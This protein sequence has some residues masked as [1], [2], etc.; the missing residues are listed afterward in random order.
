MRAA[1]SL[2]SFV[3]ALLGLPASSGFAA[4]PLTRIKDTKVAVD[5]RATS[6]VVPPTHALSQ[7]VTLSNYMRLPCEQYVLIPMPLGSN[8]SVRSDDGE[9]GG[10]R[11]GPAAERS[12]GD[13]SNKCILRGSKFIETS[14]LNDRFDFSVTTTLTWEDALQ[15]ISG[16]G[17]IEGLQ[18]EECTGCSITADTSIDVDV[19]VPPPFSRIPKRILERTGNAAMR[20]SLRYIQANFVNNLAAD[21]AK[22]ATDSAYRKYRASLSEGVGVEEE[23]MV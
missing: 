20:L 6:S 1:A 7:N 16:D 15:S 13:T 18:L 10:V 4:A 11:L 17:D 8:L 9:A 21:Y 22:W 5:G 2:G 23:V 19:D 14:Q 12:G 3:A